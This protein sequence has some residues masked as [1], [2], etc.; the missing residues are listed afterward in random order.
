LKKIKHKKEKRERND[1]KY[2]KEAK[3]L[4]KHFKEKINQCA[5]EA[6]VAILEEI[7]SNSF[8]KESDKRKLKIMIAKKENLPSEIMVKLRL[9]KD[10]AVRF[11]AYDTQR[12]KSS[13]ERRK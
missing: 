5:P 12:Q 6:L 8:L 10:R 11:W 3:K 7:E 4:L 1:K 13:F 9:D 2:K